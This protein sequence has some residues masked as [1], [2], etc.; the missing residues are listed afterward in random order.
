MMAR[1]DTLPRLLAIA[2]GGGVA[3]YSGLLGAEAQNM[4]RR[5]VG[6]GSSLCADRD[7]PGYRAAVDHWLKSDPGGMDAKRKA[8]AE[9]HKD[10][11]WLKRGDQDILCEWLRLDCE[12]RPGQPFCGTSGPRMVAFVAWAI[13]RGMMPPYPSGAGS[14]TAPAPTPVASTPARNTTDPAVQK[15]IQRIAGDLAYSYRVT[16]ASVDKAEDRGNYLKVYF[17]GSDGGKYTAYVQRDVDPMRLAEGSNV[18]NY[19]YRYY[20]TTSIG[21]SY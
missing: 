5:L 11:S 12:A 20:Y 10:P 15:W 6:G 13:E 18:G 14:T 7:D 17:T 4:I 8:I 9:H 2:A 19:G 16:F 1:S 21:R 3:A